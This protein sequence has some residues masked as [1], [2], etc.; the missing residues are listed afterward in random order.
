MGGQ[1]HP[2]YQIVE[3]CRN[4]CGKLFACVPFYAKSAATLLCLGADEIVL[5]EFAQLGPLDTQIRVEPRPGKPEYQSALNPFKTLEQ[6]Q[7]FSVQTLDIAMKTIMVRSGLDMDICLKHSIAFVE[8]TTGPLIG[9]LDPE[10]LGEYSRALAVGSE[11]ATRLMSRFSGKSDDEIKNIVDTLVHGYP[12]HDY[13][14]DCKELQEIGL[15]ASLFN[16]E[17]H[18][19]VEPVVDELAKG[20]AHIHLYEPSPNPTNKSNE[21][22]SE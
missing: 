15:P 19:V 3:I 10:K 12:S 17:E 2:A 1:I 22:K 4:H 14:I 21:Q 11:Y 5:D 8:A 20:V 16:D 9:R 7:K 6:L 13:I 18:C